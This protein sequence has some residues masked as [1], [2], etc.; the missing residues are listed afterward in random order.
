VRQLISD[1]SQN[2]GVD[3][4]AAA[5]AGLSLVRRLLRAGFLVVKRPAELS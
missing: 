2:D 5:G 1:V 4:A 3:F